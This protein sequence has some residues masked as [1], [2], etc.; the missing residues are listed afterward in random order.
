[1]ALLRKDKVSSIFWEPHIVTG[2]RQTDT[3]F[4]QCIKYT[5]IIHN[6]WGNF[7]THFITLWLWLYWLYR[8][9]HTLDLTHPFWYPLLS[10]WAGGCAYVFF[11]SMAHA[12]GSKS[13]KVRQICFMVDYLGI[14]LYGFGSC[15]AS[16]F[17]EQPLGYTLFAYTRTFVLM[18]FLFSLLSTFLC[19]LTR[20]YWEKYRYVI[21]AGSF[22]FSYVGGYFPVLVRMIGPCYIGGEDCVDE[23]IPI[24]FIA[25]ALSF[26][27]PFFF[28]TKIPE[29]FFP[30]KFDYFFQSHQVFHVCATMFTSVQYYLTIK[31]ASL[32]KPYLMNSQVIP[33]AYSTL[34]PFALVFVVGCSIVGVFSYFVI[35][36][37]LISNKKHEKHQ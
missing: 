1:M 11:S 21:R 23:T 24:H 25:M 26:T 20:F 22:L 32:R 14:S 2:Y 16:Y 27:I 3:S 29:R 35:N 5:L 9:S 34:Y 4:W 17:Y 30:G 8:V 10:L 7:W 31:D 18:Y 28:I 36:E 37:V 33:D 13:I 6:D 19:C 12:F 15:I